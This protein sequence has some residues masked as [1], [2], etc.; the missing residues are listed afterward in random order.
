MTL[1]PWGSRELRISPEVS[2]E[3]DYSNAWEAFSFSS[4][5]QSRSTLCGPMDCSTPGFPVHHQLPALAQTHVHRVSDAISHLILCRPP[6]LLP[7]IS[8][9][10]F[11][12]WEALVTLIWYHPSNLYP[13]TPYTPPPDLFS[14]QDREAGN[15]GQL[16]PFCIRKRCPSNFNFLVTVIFLG[17]WAPPSG[18]NRRKD[19]LVMLFSVTHPPPTSCSQL[20][21]PSCPSHCSWN[22]SFFPRWLGLLPHK[23]FPVF[24]NIMN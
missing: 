16:V 7:S 14:D 18:S 19:R 24:K 3:R 2:K 17:C 13:P 11:N 21:W 5:A 23:A 9:H 10:A 1:R 15:L 20:P 6:L 12:A 22:D 8:S 4:V